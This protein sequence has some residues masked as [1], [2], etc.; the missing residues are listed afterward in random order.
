[1][2]PREIF[3]KRNR[4]LLREMVKTDFKLRYQGSILGH[5]WSILKPLALF[6]VMYLVFVQFLRFGAGIPHF[7]VA[8]LLGT[9]IWQFFAEA[10]SQGMSSIVARGDL[11]RKINF[12]KVIVV[13]SAVVGALVNFVINLGVV[14]V[15]AIANGV[16][17][18]WYIILAV[19]LVIELFF[20]ALGLAL[21]LAA[22]Y[23]KFRDITHI[24]EIAMQGWFYATPI[25]YPLSQI[26]V[27]KGEI[28]QSHIIY[29]KALMLSPIAQIIQDMRNV[30][31]TPSDT[32]WSFLHNPFAQ[33][34]PFVVVLLL[35]WLGVRVFNKQSQKFAEEI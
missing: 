8:L 10:V 1:M 23:V 16:E 30:M 7:A 35:V 9:T 29:A 17:F 11:L 28:I 21:L 24:W 2:K 33:A 15:F 12:P 31:I 6:L 32:I 4:V 34:V 19:P 26:Y 27:D 13:L 20:F 14:L 5:L 3:S 22:L 18:H 25:I